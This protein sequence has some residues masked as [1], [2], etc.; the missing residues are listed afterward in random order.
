MTTLADGRPHEMAL[1]RP[2]LQ[3]IRLIR[4]SRV[5]TPDQVSRFAR[6]IGRFPIFYFSFNC[7]K[8][9]RD[10]RSYQSQLRLGAANGRI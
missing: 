3:R 8:L 4:T 2:G 7:S 5:R 10:N 6:R 1:D 9:G